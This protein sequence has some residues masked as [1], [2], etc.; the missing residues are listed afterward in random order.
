MYAVIVGVLLVAAK[1]AEFGPFAGW[2]WWIVLAP[3]A[4]ALAWWFYADATGLTKKR[5]IRRMEERK[6]E[7]RRKA[8]EALGL[9]MSS[10][11]REEA[12]RRARAVVTNPIERQRAEKRKQNKKQILDS[13][14]NSRQS[15]GFEDSAQARKDPQA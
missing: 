7:R 9:T 10:G 11:E 6:V 8:A 1:L 14:F 13:V 15:A 3:F 12:L 5:E 2:S 4:L